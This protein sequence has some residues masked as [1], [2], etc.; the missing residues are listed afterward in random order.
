MRKLMFVLSALVI[1]S[2]LLTACGGGQ[3]AAT[4]APVATQ[5]PATQAPA[6]TEAPAT[7]AATEAPTAVPTPTIPPPVLTGGEGC[8]PA[9]TKVTWFVGLGA[10]SNADVVPLER[11]G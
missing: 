8:D 1:A 5:A 4:Q 6:A 2:M 9:A 7:A 10:C 3:P 11:L